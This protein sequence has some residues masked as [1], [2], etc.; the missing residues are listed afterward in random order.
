MDQT[1]DTMLQ[2]ADLF[3]N[4]SFPDESVNHHANKRGYKEKFL[5][6]I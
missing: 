2:R 5:N 1:V 4:F 3:D 6:A